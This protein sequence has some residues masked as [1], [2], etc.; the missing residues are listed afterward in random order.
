MITLDDVAKKAGVS[1]STVSIV[2]NDRKVRGVSISPAT[3]ERV[4]HFAREMG[5]TPNGL[6]RAMATGKNRVIGLIK[7]D[8]ST[9]LAMRI[10]VGAQTECEKSGYLIKP[11]QLPD[12]SDCHDV[13]ERCL[14]QRV[15]GIILINLPDDA[16]KYIWEKASSSNVPVIMLDQLPVEDFGV[17]ITSDDE[18]GV[19]L[20]CDHLIKMGHHRIGY[21]GG[22]PGNN[23]SNMRKEYVRAAMDERGVPVFEQDIHD[24]SWG[25]PEPVNV[26]VGKLLGRPDQD[27]PTAL[28]CAGDATAMMAIRAARRMGFDLPREISITGYS[29]ARYAYLCDPSLTTVAQDF[30]GMGRTAVRYLLGS[31]NASGSTVVRIP[32]SLVVRESVGVGPF[33]NH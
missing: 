13:A 24:G 31:A 11:F 20:M 8:V 32:T 14:S 1:A 9:E 2:V 16:A 21:I 7:D 18:M 17:R 3:R 23:L 6:A 27:R 29:N 4:L 30:E 15:A 25:D 26:S 10:M 33:Y 19:R 28:F 5:Y 12:L 22:D